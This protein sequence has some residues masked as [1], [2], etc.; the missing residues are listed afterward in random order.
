MVDFGAS[1]RVGLE[2][3][4]RMKMSSPNSAG[5][6]GSRVAS[7]GNGEE[8]VTGWRETRALQ[9]LARVTTV[10]GSAGSSRE[11]FLLHQSMAF[12][13]LQGQGRRLTLF[14]HHC[15]HCTV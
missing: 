7:D 4:M 13:T 5:Y 10:R 2:Y 14:A 1:V 11:F 3:L 15:S 12:L 6:P 9:A 8:F